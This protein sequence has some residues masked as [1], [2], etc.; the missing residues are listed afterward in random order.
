MLGDL[1][2]FD[3]SVWLP[4][5]LIP[6]FP[7]QVRDDA[8]HQIHAEVEMRDLDEQRAHALQSCLGQLT[9]G[10]KGGLKVP[11]AKVELS[12]PFTSASNVRR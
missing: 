2:G 7:A 6:R 10:C 11:S 12:L 9:L 4:A 8:I 3:I 5:Y 1:D